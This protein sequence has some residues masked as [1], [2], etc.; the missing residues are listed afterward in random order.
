MKLRF[1]NAA[2]KS[3]KIVYIDDIRLIG[4]TMAAPAN[5]GLTLMS[6]GP[7]MAFGIPEIEK[8]TIKVYPNP[9]INNLSLEVAGAEN[10]SVF[11]YNSQGQQIYYGEWTDNS[12]TIDVSNFD[13]GLYVVKVI[14]NGEMITTRV[15]KQ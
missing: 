12:Q 7:S 14:N 4:S 3:D 1:M 15:L 8:E 9:A 11:I 6:Q 13:R 5:T 10:M 2:K